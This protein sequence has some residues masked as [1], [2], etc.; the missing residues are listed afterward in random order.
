MDNT[1]KVVNLLGEARALGLEILPPD[2]T[3]SGYKFE[4]LDPPAA[5][6]TSKTIR[7]GLGAIKGVGEGAIDNVVM[8]RERGGVFRDLADFCLRVDAQ[9]INKRTLEALILSGSMD[10]LGKNRA[11]LMAQLPEAMRAAEQ[12]ARDA[13]AGQ[14]DMFGSSTAAATT[15]E[16]IELEDWPAE[17]RLAGERDTLG[18]YLSGHPTDAWRDLLARVTT[19]PIGDIGRL[20]KP[21]EGRARYAGGGQAFTLAGSVLSLRKQG[22]SRAFV[23]VEDFSGRFEAILYREAWSEYAPLL[24]R[25][26]ILV[27]EGSLS[28]DDFT[29]NFQMRTQR[30]AT[31]ESACERQARVLRLRVNGIG[32]DFASRLYAILETCRG[33]STAVRIAFSNQSGRGEIELGPEWRVRASPSLVQTVS[34]LDGV[35]D[36]EYLYS[37]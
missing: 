21:Q 8:M 32:E 4:A 14:N 13:Q 31:I 34:A 35:L 3:A 1:D 36:A 29:G 17:R 11:S 26:A 20:C 37:Q 30:V 12:S 2:I 16:R 33:G 7:Y 27:F 15:L 10:A 9:K 22:E 18:H 24:T 5:G 23:Q 28:I 6:A 19:C 25:D